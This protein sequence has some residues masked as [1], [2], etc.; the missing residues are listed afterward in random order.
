MNFRVRQRIALVPIALFIPY[1]QA[2]FFALF[3]LG[4]NFVPLGAKP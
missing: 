3:R 2:F 4:V 1:L